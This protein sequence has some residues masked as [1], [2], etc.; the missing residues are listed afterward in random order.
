MAFIFQRR[1]IVRQVQ[2]QLDQV[3]REQEQQARLQQQSSGEEDVVVDFDDDEEK[4]KNGCTTTTSITATP[5]PNANLSDGD[6][7]NGGGGGSGTPQSPSAQ[8]DPY[9]RLPGVTPGIDRDG[10]P[11]YCVGWPTSSSSSFSASPGLL[12]DPQNPKQWPTPL[13]LLCTSLV[14]LIAL[15]TTAASSIDSVAL[16]PA[17]AEFGVSPLTESLA[18]GL[19]LCGFGAGALLASPLSELAGRLPVYA[20]ALAALCGFTAGSAAAPGGIAGQLAFRALM[21]LAASPP[22]TVAGG[23]VSDLWDHRERTWAF[24]MYAVPGF[25]GAVLGEFLFFSFLS[26]LFSFNPLFIFLFCSLRVC[27]WS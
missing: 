13:R 16:A 27:F 26:F 21:G 7:E 1:S 11:Y 23:T 17:S 20:G 9:L 4:R 10:L 5:I 12:P 2:E 8:A 15:T 19:F 3:A 25:G 6:L 22:L 14:C 18:T 24:P